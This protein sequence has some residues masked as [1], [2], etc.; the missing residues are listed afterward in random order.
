MIDALQR[1]FALFEELRKNGTINA[2][3][4][5]NNASVEEAQLKVE[6]RYVKYVVVL[7]RLAAEKPDF[8][9]LVDQ[10]VLLRRVKKQLFTHYNHN[11]SRTCKWENVER[12]TPVYDPFVPEAVRA[13]HAASGMVF[14]CLLSGKEH[15]CGKDRCRRYS[16]QSHGEVSCEISGL[17]FD[18]VV[19]T[20]YARSK[21]HIQQQQAE[22]N[23]DGLEDDGGGGAADEYIEIAEPVELFAS[24]AGQD[25]SSIATLLTN[26]DPEISEK[27]SK[28]TET[29]SGPQEERKRKL[30]QRAAL[31]ASLTLGIEDRSGDAEKKRKPNPPVKKRT[32][33]PRN[34]QIEDRSGDAGASETQVVLEHD[35]KTLQEYQRAFLMGQAQSFAGAVQ[36]NPRQERD[37]LD[38]QNYG[39]DVIVS[40]FY[41]IK[42]N[43]R[44]LVNDMYH[45]VLG[46]PKSEDTFNAAHQKAIESAE[47]LADRYVSSMLT[48]SRIPDRSRVYEIYMRFL[49]PLLGQ[50]FSRAFGQDSDVAAR[51]YFAEAILKVWKI[52]D[53][54]PQ[55]GNLTPTTTSGGAATS[56]NR[57]SSTTKTTSHKKARIQLRTVALAILYKLR[58]GIFTMVD[59]DPETNRALSKHQAQISTKPLK[60]ERLCFI[61]PHEY[62]DRL[63]NENQ[64]SRMKLKT[65]D[66]S[67]YVTGRN[68]CNCYTS[69][70]LYGLPMDCVRQYQLA[71][72]MPIRFVND[73]VLEISQEIAAECKKD[74]KNNKIVT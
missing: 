16:R 38:R 32:K 39:R 62:L 3:T 21:N 25:E 14:V 56:A 73:Q 35:A 26:D 50:T 41:D 49:Y 29:A 24:T 33:R 57:N 71:A 13:K 12:G 47:A 66:S 52:I 40:S 48:A 19:T 36:R 61:P 7:N 69:L 58:D 55:L 8:C 9:S 11:C 45:E 15:I 5:V 18:S 20:V 22:H 34:H 17:S 43:Y 28:T 65:V 60:T 54:T 70:L 72:H 46:G 6:K 53:C 51:E 63:P 37:R 68:I 30:L 1:D 64:L 31:A 10:Y 27:L 44:K 23:G 4:S 74:L 2:H 59:Y 42:E 67:V